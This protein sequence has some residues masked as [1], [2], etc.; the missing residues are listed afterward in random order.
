MIDDIICERFYILADEN[1]VWEGK[2]ITTMVNRFKEYYELFYQEKLALK[3]EELI[4]F[5]QDE[6]IIAPCGCLY[7]CVS[8]QV[9]REQGAK[10]HINLIMRN[11]I[12][13][14]TIG[15]TFKIDVP[16][17]LINNLKIDSIKLEKGVWRLNKGSWGEDK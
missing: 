2:H 6:D 11:F 10:R 16:L 5:A 4:K 14:S 1:S 8:V 7:R 3:K 12:E 13:R 9:K 15:I 17:G